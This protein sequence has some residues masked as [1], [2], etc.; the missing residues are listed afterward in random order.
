VGY[1]GRMLNAGLKDKF[2]TESFNDLPE[3]PRETGIAGVGG[4]ELSCGCDQ[5]LLSFLVGECAA[6][7][8]CRTPYTV[9][10]CSAGTLRASP[11]MAQVELYAT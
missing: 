11:E 4:S 3:D 2:C 8:G 10:R 6:L 5:S 7:M 1:S 9:R